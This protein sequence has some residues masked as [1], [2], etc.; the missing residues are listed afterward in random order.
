VFSEKIVEVA[1]PLI[2]RANLVRFVEGRHQSVT[3]Y[4]DHYFVA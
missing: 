2:E 3:G 1:N 4:A